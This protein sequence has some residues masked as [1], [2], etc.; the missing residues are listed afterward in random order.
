MLW[1]T[2]KKIHATHFMVI[3]ILLQGTHNIS[4]VCLY[5][6]ATGRKRKHDINRR[7]RN[8]KCLIPLLRKMLGTGSTE[9]EYTSALEENERKFLLLQPLKLYHRYNQALMRNQRYADNEG[10]LHI[11]QHWI[12][13]KLCD[14]KI[15]INSIYAQ[16]SKLCNFQTFV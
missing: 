10:Q 13:V 8:W 14:I 7:D 11:M 3:F 12:N 5:T 16:N 4:V 9:S 6:P 1:E 2:K 15:L